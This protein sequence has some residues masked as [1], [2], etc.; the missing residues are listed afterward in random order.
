MNQNARRHAARSRSPVFILL[1]APGVLIIGAAIVVMLVLLPPVLERWVRGSRPIPTR[2]P[3]TQVELD[4]RT[5]A[6]A[7]LVDAAMLQLGVGSE[8]IVRE[9]RS[10][11]ERESLVW[12]SIY[13]ETHLPHDMDIERLIDTLVDLKDQLPD[14]TT[15]DVVHADPLRIEIYVTAGKARIRYELLRVSL[16]PELSI[17]SEQHPNVVLVMLPGSHGVPEPHTEEIPWTVGLLPFD[18]DTPSLAEQWTRAGHEVL[19][20]VD[21]AEANASFDPATLPS[22]LD[23]V[24]NASGVL[25]V[26]DARVARDPRKLELITGQLKE[27]GLYLVDHWHHPGSSAVRVAGDMGVEAISVD[28]LL[29]PSDADDIESVLNRAAQIAIYRGLVVIATS[30]AQEHLDVIDAWVPQ[31]RAL[32]FH[33]VFVHEALR[34]GPPNRAELFLLEDEA[35]SDDSEA[36]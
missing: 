19:S 1:T 24:P 28:M 34:D 29:V 9:T 25:M 13:R 22:R 7:A 11:E 6:A 16:G 3:L 36:G 5:M 33:F 17:S 27:R 8:Y 2:P 15:I 31:M 4:E 26:G 10:V 14:R 20:V 35:Y 12:E 23:S 32:G 30:P 21:L 18:P